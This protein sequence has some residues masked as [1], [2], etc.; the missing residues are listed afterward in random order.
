[1]VFLV[2]NKKHSPHD[3]CSSFFD[4]SDKNADFVQSVLFFCVA[5]L[6]IRSSCSVISP[7]AL[8]R[9][10]AILSLNIS[11]YLQQWLRN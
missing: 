9:I 2:L 11:N 1:M 7:H 10:R 8:S 4:F 3:N 6:C 5:F